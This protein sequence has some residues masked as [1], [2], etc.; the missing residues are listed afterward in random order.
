MPERI[1][2]NS[3]SYSICDGDTIRETPGK[4]VKSGQYPIYWHLRKKQLLSSA[5]WCRFDI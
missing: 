1:G 3:L 2:M 4:N 5:N